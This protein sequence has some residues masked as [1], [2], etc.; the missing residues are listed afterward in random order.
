MLNVGLSHTLVRSCRI[1]I[2][3]RVRQRGQFLK[4][5]LLAEKDEV[6]S[7][8]SEKI[9]LLLLVPFPDDRDF[10][11]HPIAQ[12]NRTLFAHIIHYDTKKVLIRNTFDCLFHISHCQRLGHILDICY[13]NCFLADTDFVFDIVAVLSQ[14]T[15]FFEH[16]L[17]CTLTPIGPSMK[18]ILDNGVRIYRNKYVVTLLDQLVAE[19]PFIWECKGF[20]RIPPEYWMKVPLKPG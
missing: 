2:A 5:R 3:V 19:Y 7:P 1:K 6:I 15:P 18:M 12:P 14:T 4:R 9:I 13:N 8:R 20:V 10:L 11:F 16:E 17:S